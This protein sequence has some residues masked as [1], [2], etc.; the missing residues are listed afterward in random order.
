MDAFVE[1]VL[2]NF[3]KDDISCVLATSYM[4]ILI[5]VLYL[6]GRFN[7]PKINALIK[8]ETTNKLARDLDLEERRLPPYNAKDDEPTDEERLESILQEMYVSSLFADPNI[9]RVHYFPQP[10]LRRRNP[11]RS[12]LSPRGQSFFPP[13]SGVMVKR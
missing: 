7:N 9:R 13:V 2:N 4:G 5:F 3:S 1:L 11:G 8:Q 12:Q 10:Q 6:L